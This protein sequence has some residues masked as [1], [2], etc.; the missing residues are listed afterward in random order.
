MSVARAAFSLLFVVLSAAC[1]DP[2]PLPSQPAPR[3]I[4]GGCHE[5]EGDTCSLEVRTQLS[6]WLDINAGTPLRVLA[7]GKPIQSTGRVVLGGVRLSIEVPRYTGSLRIESVDETWDPPIELVFTWEPPP[8]IGEI[9][10]QDTLRKLSREA[11]GWKKL[12]LIDTLRRLNYGKKEAV[13]LGNRQLVLARKL[14]ARQHQAFVLGA[15]ARDL[16]DA[17][18]DLSRA[19]ELLDELEPLTE[20]SNFAASRRHYFRGVLARRSGDLGAALKHLTAA[21]SLYEQLG[22]PALLDPLEQEAAALADLGRVEDSR[23][24]RRRAFDPA[25]SGALTCLDHVRRANNLAWAELVLRSAGLGDSDPRPMMLDALARVEACPHKWLRASLQLDLG[26]AAVQEGSAEE[27]LGWLAEA[28]DIPPDLEPWF[29][30]V[31]AQASIQHADR[32]LHPPLIQVPLPTADPQLLWNQT[33]RRAQ[34]LAEWGFS[35]LA[36]AEYRAAEAQLAKSLDRVGIDAGGELYLAGR[37]ASLEGLVNV[38]LE[39]GQPR[40]ASCAIRLARARELARLDR[41]SRLQAASDEERNTWEREVFSI[42]A[43]QTAIGKRQAGLWELSSDEKVQL[44]AQLSQRD[45]AGRRRLDG[46]LRGLGFEPTPRTCDELREARAGEV[47]LTVYASLAFATSQAGVEVAPLENLDALESLSGA[48]SISIIEVGDHPQATIHT[49]PW[50]DEASLLDVAPVAYSLDLPRRT[51]SPATLRR[52]L[53][54]ADP[55]NDLPKSREEASEVTQRLDSQGWSVTDASGSQ[56]THSLL[57]ARL[58]EVDLFHYAGHGV[59]EGMSGWDSALLLA[60]DERLRVHDVFTLPAVPRGV[61]LTGCETAAATPQTV[62]GG[63]NI[64]RAFILSGSDWVVASDAEVSDEHAAAV[65]IA[66][67]DAESLEGPARLREAL[68]SLRAKD[69]KAPWQHF[70][71]ITP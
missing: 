55:R 68:L 35:E 32:S 22:D 28:D 20:H 3:T 64:G 7:D 58:P 60:E 61:V 11:T 10:E 57:L 43:E 29:A 70:R 2:A 39:L 24:L 14:G 31:R 50:R 1:E 42:A 4:F 51:P 25:K 34:S 38:L 52:A 48:Q 23:H 33:V 9:P 27:A 45:S 12:R 18:S 36:V 53:V 46:A 63:M 15:Q 62:G 66:M 8:W 71:A 49:L 44:E 59:R 41:P 26:L 69:P 37:T 13:E 16:I 30:E 19:R 6:A 40:E 47:I 67:H 56:A 5:L 54:V 21:R 17:G 65:G